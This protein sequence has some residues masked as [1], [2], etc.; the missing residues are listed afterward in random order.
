MTKDGVD[1]EGVLQ[2][3]LEHRLVR[4]LLSRFLSQGFTS[5]LSRASVVIG[6]GAQ[7][8]VVLLGRLAL[9][10]PGAARLH[11]EI[12]LVTAAWT[13]LRHGQSALKP[14]GAV[15]EAATLEQ[16]DQAFG[17][18]RTP[19]Q[20]IIERIRPWAAE[21]AKDLE[22]ELRRRAEARKA[23]AIRD[24]AAVGDTEARAIRRLLEDQRARVAKADAEPEDMQL[25]LFD[26]AEA[27]QR[28]RDRRRWK[29]KLEKL[30][31]DIAEE[32]ERV[33]AGYNVVADRLET[34]GL[35]YLWPEGN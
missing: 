27:E 21:D 29:A 4:R 1:V 22:P 23:E 30:A 31:K 15:R 6:P 16:L 19:S 2:L 7:P 9:Y 20:Q 13:E 14:F 18:P 35:V 34:I 28:R 12:L 11:E 8:R 33:R 3:H 26:E 32:P 17:D 24:L 5:G 10:G 25:S